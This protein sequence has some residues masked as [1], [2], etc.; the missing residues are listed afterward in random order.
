MVLRAKIL[1]I[2]KHIS[3]FALLACLYSLSA[4]TTKTIRPKPVKAIVYLTGAEISYLENMTLPAG[5]N[6]VVIEGVSPGTD[7]NSISA[8]FKGALVIDTKKSQRYP[9]PPKLYNLESKY[10]PIIERIT[11]SLEEL[12]FLFKDCNNKHAAFEKEKALL[13]DNSMIRGEFTKDSIALLKASLDLLR[14]RLS[15][16]DEQQLLI[17]RKLSKLYK[18][19]SKLQERQ[20]Y[21]A[22]LKQSSSPFI[23]TEQYQAIHQVI[24][25]I[26]AEQP[27]TGSLSLKYYVRSA[28][29]L[30]MYDIQASSGK[31]KIQLVYRAQVY[32]NTGLDWKDVSLVLSTSNPAIGNTKPMLSAWNLSYGY[33][34]SYIEDVNKGKFSNG[35]AFSNMNQ[36]PGR[37]ERDQIKATWDFGDA[38]ADTVSMSS[39]QELNMPV[40]TMNDNLLRT[41]YE[42]KAKYSIETDNKPH[43]VI[44][45]NIEIPVSLA[46]LAVPK[47][48][49]DA[50]LMGKVANWEDLNLLPAAAKIYFDESYIGM[51]AVDPATTKDTLYLNLGRDKSII[52]KRM[53]IREKS[54]ETI[55]G[56][57][58]VV[59]KTIEITVRNTK[60]I[61]LQFELE[62]Q[63]PVTIDNSIKISMQENNATFYNEATGKLTWKLNIKPKDTKK[64]TFT[65]EIKYP[66]DKYIAGL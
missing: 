46:Y 51:T 19:Q 38:K 41:E 9:E 4:Q 7:E 1:Y 18:L 61:N 58:K 11:D 35:P 21:Y 30:P 15:N 48:D 29:W 66:K 27:V 60:G 31:E 59:T 20:N 28:G 24:V 63:I 45:N 22:L 14:V 36:Y 50:F 26:E 34:N 64:V 17:E 25:T 42:I 47:L 12:D 57:F 52:I 43:N 54:K 56:D 5:T 49:R 62:D 23:S 2:M 37:L 40:F 6:Q 33:P 13:L 39:S 53:A 55:M 3:L 65:Y 44:I 10:A 8:Y 16:I 32:Q